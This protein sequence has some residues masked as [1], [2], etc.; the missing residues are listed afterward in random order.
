MSE[1][2]DDHLIDECRQI[3]DDCLYTAET[4][5]MMAAKFSR[6][7][8]WVKLIPAVAAAASGVALLSGAPNWVAW[9]SVISGVAFALQSIMSPDKKYEEHSKAGKS[10]TALKHESRSLYKT[11]CKEID[12][13]CFS[14]TV[15]ILR[16]RYNTTAM[17][18]PQ[19]S[20]KA[21]EKARE[22]IK[23]G[24]H[25]PDFEEQKPKSNG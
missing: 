3:E 18:T 23:S 6:V 12:R 25:T 7:G 4:H 1:E 11:F 10:Y 24:R 17:H 22:R 15:R 14:T 21:F 8:F 5:Y 9:F 2:K 19:T 13:N 20:V 16:E